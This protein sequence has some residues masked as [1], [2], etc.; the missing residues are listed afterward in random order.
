MTVAE[1]IEELRNMPP[2]LEAVIKP[3][4][5]DTSE[6]RNFF[7]AVN[8]IEFDFVNNLVVISRGQK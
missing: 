6:Q 2:S 4:V 5:V 1:L 3:E 8:K 7:T